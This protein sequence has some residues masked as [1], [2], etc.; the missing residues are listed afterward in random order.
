[1]KKMYETSRDLDRN[2][3]NFLM[4]YRNTLHSVTNQ[5]PS[6]L[7]YGRTLR[8][9]LHHLRPSD[10]CEAERWDT[11]KEQKIIDN[12][13]KIRD[14]KENQTVWVQPTNEKTWRTATIVRQHGNS[15][16]YDVNYDGR[17]I[18]KHADSLKVR[19]VPII[20]LTNQK[21]PSSE[22]KT[23]AQ[24]IIVTQPAVGETYQP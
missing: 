10:Q 14:F 18:K 16:V 12:Q 21:I 15:P 3:A 20:Q 22:E 8:S 24:P 7:M 19:I 4:T 17:I 1:M 11:D 9:R 23:R 5:P 6:V 2:L 13:Q